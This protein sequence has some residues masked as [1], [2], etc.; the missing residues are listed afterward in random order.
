MS[1]DQERQKLKKAYPTSTR[2]AKR[3]DKM[4]DAQVFAVLMRLKA[5]KIIKE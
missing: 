2:W 3:V 5:K 4:S 1:L